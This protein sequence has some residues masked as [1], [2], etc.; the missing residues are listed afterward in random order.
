MCETGVSILP[1]SVLLAKLALSIVIWDNLMF[2]VGNCRQG[3]IFHMTT[4][5]YLSCDSAC[6]L[7]VFLIDTLQILFSNSYY[8]MFPAFL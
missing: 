8:V 5:N 6:I 2:L 3:N 7:N 4:S 1:I